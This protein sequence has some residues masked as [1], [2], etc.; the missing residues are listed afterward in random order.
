M[1]HLLHT[2]LE[3]NLRKKVWQFPFPLV[4]ALPKLERRK[5]QIFISQMGGQKH[6]AVEKLGGNTDIT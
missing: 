5:K 3:L 1:F 6:S 2:S 4:S